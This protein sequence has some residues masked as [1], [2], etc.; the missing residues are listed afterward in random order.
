MISL[1]GAGW[2][3]DDGRTIPTALV[4]WIKAVMRLLASLTS[5]SE[6]FSGVEGEAG[7]QLSSE[8]KKVKFFTG[9]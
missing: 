9:F 1:T 8:R 2:W 7:G 6:A 5:F 4:L 3:E